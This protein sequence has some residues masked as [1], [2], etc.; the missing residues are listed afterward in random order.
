MGCAW[1]ATAEED[2]SRRG[3]ARRAAMLGGVAIVALAELLT[4]GAVHAQAAGDVG[5]VVVTARRRAEQLRDV[6]AAVTAITEA[7]RQ[8][9][10]LDRMEDYLRQ[11]QGVTLV[12]SGPEYLNDI[13]IRGQGSGRVGFTET[14]TGLYRDGLYNSG[15]GFGGRSL[16]RMDLFD[17]ARVEVLRG[18]QGALFGRNAVGGA[19]NV[20]SNAP[21]SEFGGTATVR[22]SDPDRT[23]LEAIVN[24]PLGDKLAARLGGFISDQHDGF[25]VNTTTGDF[26]DTQNSKGARLTL[27]ARPSAKVTLGA[28]AEYYDSSAP[29]FT[30][31]ARSPTLDA[32]PDIRANQ[33]RQGRTDIKEK[34]FSLRADVDLDWA[35]MALRA[36]HRDRDGARTNEDDD[37]FV[38]LSLSDVAP[39]AAVSYPDYSRAQ[40]E[41]YRRDVAQVTFASK[42]GGRVSWLV[43]VEYLNSKDHVVTEPLDCPAY[44]GAAL[45]ATP[46]CFVGTAAAGAATTF[47][48]AARQ[49]G[50]GTMNHDTFNEKVDSI[51]LFGAIEAKLAERWLLGLELRAQHDSRDYDFERWSEDPLVYFGSGTVPTGLL[52]PIGGSGATT[53]QF[54][55]PT[56]TAPAC[57]AG[58]ETA[59]VRTG[60]DSTFYTPTVSL[61][62]NLADEQNLYWRFATAYRSGGF[63]TN[64]PPSV[65][66]ALLPQVLRYDAEYA[67]NYETGWKGRLFGFNAEAAVYYTWTNQV[68]VVTAPSAGA[69]GFILSNAGDAHVYGFE[70]EARRIFRVGRGRLVTRVS[71]STS[72]GAFEKG[73]SLISQGVTVDLNG[74]HVPRLRDNQ[75]TANLL[76]TQ[77]IGRLRGF[78]GG[79]AQ[80][81]HGGYETPDNVRAYAGYTLY[82][83]RIGVE[84]GNWRFSVTGRNLTDERY[85]LNVVGTAEFWN[86]PRIYG[87]ELTLRY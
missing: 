50:R 10:V 16:T 75:V 70:A 31:L 74:K 5:E 87:A 11:I 83:A 32:G 57:A 15:G 19:V 18:P 51:S 24:L 29:G 69:T 45:A 49:A 12:T 40:F 14:A 73:A 25:I 42:K 84:G 22:R 3:A 33:N 55:P 63:N 62:W 47:S 85:V 78:I 44:T 13:S 30:G 56:L 9:L 66:R 23:D 76:Y 7:D 6:P 43:G 53:V 21:R 80:Y 27:E 61:R 60:F 59:T 41:D 17:N 67:Y 52:A 37:H 82:D 54:C 34:G 81:A 20:I 58:N 4:A 79:S 48:P 71:Y 72:D 68:Q 39:G 65:T 38:G 86:Q 35:D 1:A 46:G 77:P 64:L 26:T 8:G 2:S 28:M 36:S